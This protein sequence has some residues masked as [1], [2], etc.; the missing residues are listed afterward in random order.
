MLNIFQRNKT[1]IND[2][3][4]FQCFRREKFKSHKFYSYS[5]NVACEIYV[6]KF[7]GALKFAVDRIDCKVKLLR[8]LVGLVCEICNLCEQISD[9]SLSWKLC[10]IKKLTYVLFLS[11]VFYSYH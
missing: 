5:E 7:S 9:I 6:D 10:S 1:Y 8:K 4:C 11:L 2:C 3:L